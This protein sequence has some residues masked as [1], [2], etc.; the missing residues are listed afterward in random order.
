MGSQLEFGLHVIT[1]KTILQDEKAFTLSA[2]ILN[3]KGL[4][5]ILDCDK[6]DRPKRFNVISK[7]FK[8]FNE[9]ISNLR[10]MMDP[11]FIDIISRSGVKNNHII[12]RREI[13][14]KPYVNYIFR[15]VK[16]EESWELRITFCH[17]YMQTKIIIPSTMLENFV[18]VFDQLVQAH[19]DER[20]KYSLRSAISVN[21]VDEIGEK[22]INRLII[23]NQRNKNIYYINLNDVPLPKRRDLAAQ[24]NMGPVK[25]ECDQSDYFLEVI[26]KNASYVK[27][28]DFSRDT[29]KSFLFLPMK[30]LGQ[31]EDEIKKTADSFHQNVIY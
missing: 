21:H 30:I 17:H 6:N 24:S 18:K 27:I 29:T 11:D 1:S 10:Q 31:L 14:I 13:V 28:S 20:K 5:E 25:V 8:E 23:S 12:H 9:A 19:R 2:K 3:G 22:L 15:L 16:T 26:Q 7:Y 4:I